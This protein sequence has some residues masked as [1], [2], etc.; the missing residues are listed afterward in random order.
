MDQRLNDEERELELE[1]QEL[2]RVLIADAQRA[3]EESMRLTGS[4]T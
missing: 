2:L 1:R 3:L 4:P